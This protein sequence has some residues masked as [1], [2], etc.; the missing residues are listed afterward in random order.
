MGD[1]FRGKKGKQLSGIEYLVRN[2][3][4]WSTKTLV[5]HIRRHGSDP[6]S[7]TNR[8]T[9]IVQLA[10]LMIKHDELMQQ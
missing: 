9:L 4:T 7:L 5:E 1:T 10:H 6:E 2:L 3:N 8:Q